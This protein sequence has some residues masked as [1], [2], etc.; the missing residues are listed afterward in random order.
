MK[1]I[2]SLLLSWPL[3]NK[4]IADSSQVEKNPRQTKKPHH[5]PKNLPKLKPTNQQNLSPVALPIEPNNQLCSNII[6]LPMYY[7]SPEVQV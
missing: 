1:V 5:K 7:L 6:K 3:E 4:Q 2:C